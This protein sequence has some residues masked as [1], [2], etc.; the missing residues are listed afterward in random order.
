VEVEGRGTAPYCLQRRSAF[1]GGAAGLRTAA[2]EAN[3]AGLR[4]RP[5]RMWRGSRTIGDYGR[6][7][8]NELQVARY[9]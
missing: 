8:T 7:E 2:S 5:P 1:A 3:L 6:R 4:S 9:G